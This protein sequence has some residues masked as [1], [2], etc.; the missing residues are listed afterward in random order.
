MFGTGNRKIGEALSQIAQALEIVMAQTKPDPNETTTP[1]G[2]HDVVARVES[3]EMRIETYRQ[4]AV[5]HIQKASQRL[6]RAEELSEEDPEEIP[7]QI[8][9]EIQ[10]PQ[11]GT[12][13][14]SELE[15][16]TQRVRAEGN[17]PI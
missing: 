6:K 2:L 13:A 10:T 16:L 1:A 11:E 12:E 15:Y 4:D 9:L 5:R 8:P 3:L 17:T 7:P 14:P